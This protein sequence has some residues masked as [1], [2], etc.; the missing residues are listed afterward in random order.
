[1]ISF[2]DRSFTYIAIQSG[3]CCCGRAMFDPWGLHDIVTY[4]YE[5]Y[6]PVSVPTLKHRSHLEREKPRR[7]AL[8]QGT[9]R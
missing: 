2:A 6:H 1:M 8:R 7:G 5:G 3:L 9:K 4:Y